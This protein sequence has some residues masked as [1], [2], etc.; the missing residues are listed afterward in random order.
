MLRRYLLV[1]CLSLSSIALYSCKNSDNKSAPTSTTASKKKIAK[2]LSL[3]FDTFIGNNYSYTVSGEKRCE[4]DSNSTPFTEAK[5]VNISEGENCTIT[6]KSLSAKGKED[7]KI[8]IFTANDANKNLVINITKEGKLSSIYPVLFKSNDPNIP[9]QYLGASLNNDNLNLLLNSLSYIEAK[10]VAED[11]ELLSGMP[12]IPVE[13]KSLSFGV[14]YASGT[15]PENLFALEKKAKFSRKYGSDKYE[16]AKNSVELNTKLGA[17]A[18]AGNCKITSDLQLDAASL[19]L[20]TFSQLPSCDTKVEFNK[21][22]HVL[23]L[24]EGST[25]IEELKI[26]KILAVE[27]SIS[28]EQYP[29][30]DATKLNNEKSS[31]DTKFKE[32]LDAYI[33]KFL[34]KLNALNKDTDKEK[35]ATLQDKLKFYYKKLDEAFKDRLDRGYVPQGFKINGDVIEQVEEKVVEL[36]KPPAVITDSVELPKPPAVITDSVELPKPPAVITD[37]VELPK[38]PAVITDSVELPKP[39]AV[40]T[41]SVELPKPPAANTETDENLSNNELPKVPDQNLNPSNEETVIKDT[42]EEGE[43]SN[44]DDGK[45]KTEQVNEQKDDKADEATSN[46]GEVNP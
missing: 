27:E 11:I 5:E 41:D 20:E 22:Y 29:K 4:T 23:Y 18:N 7:N 45:N 36:P 32:I 44:A 39:P 26:G 46:E 35:I 14:T 21:E 15:L 40:I 2:N 33:A 6:V 17:Q 28:S 30:V 37:S 43:N 3:S 12:D 16:I 34:T 25:S 31:L 24:A 38:P 19:T 9:D 42:D 13:E 8:V 10:L 1:S